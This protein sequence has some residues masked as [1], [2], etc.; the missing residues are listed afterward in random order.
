MP[1]IPTGRRRDLYVQGGTL[2]I[3]PHYRKSSTLRAI[4][5]FPDAI[6]SALLVAFVAI[7]NPLTQFCWETL[8]PPL[9]SGWGEGP[10]PP[11]YPRHF[12]LTSDGSPWGPDGVRS[13]LETTMAKYVW[14]DGDVSACLC[15]RAWTSGR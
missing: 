13:A 12:L 5:R 10:R 8:H 11:A 4:A 9:T 14:M 2:V 15:A 7:L 6:T 1:P 3:C